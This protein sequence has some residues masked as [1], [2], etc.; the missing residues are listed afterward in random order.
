MMISAISPSRLMIFAFSSSAAAATI[1]PDCH[2]NTTKMTKT[3]TKTHA[4]GQANLQRRQLDPDK[5]G[6][7]KRCPGRVVGV[8]ALIRGT[9]GHVASLLSPPLCNRNA[10]WKVRPHRTVRGDFNIELE[11]ERGLSD[12]FRDAAMYAANRWEQIIVADYHDGG[13]MP[14]YDV[15]N[16]SGGRPTAFS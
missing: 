5:T 2:A 12:D 4:T 6:A 13:D 7:V 14:P 10:I 9:D 11:F 3:I 16:P 1:F 8:M 15:M